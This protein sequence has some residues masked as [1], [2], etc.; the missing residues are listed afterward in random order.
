M[1][2]ARNRPRWPQQAPSRPAILRRRLN[3]LKQWRGIAM[4]T[5]TTV[6]SHRA[7]THL[8]ATLIWIRTDLINTP[9][10]RQ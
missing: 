8:A 3:E 9:R 4:R 6:R 5:D 7:A 2:A 10:A 1:L